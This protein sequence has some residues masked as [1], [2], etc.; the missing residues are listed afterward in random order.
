M[1]EH[2][3]MP[4]NERWRCLRASIAIDRPSSYNG[5]ICTQSPELWAAAKRIPRREMRARAHRELREREQCALAIH[6]AGHGVGAE[7]L[8]IPCTVISIEPDWQR[9]YLGI[10]CADYTARARHSANLE[11][12]SLRAH[13]I[14][15][16]CGIVAEQAFDLVPTVP[17]F[18]RLDNDNDAQRVFECAVRV[19]RPINAPR[20]ATQKEAWHDATLRMLARLHSFADRLVRCHID[21]IEAVAAELL[22][23]TRL[24][25]AELQAAIAASCYGRDRPGR[26]RSA[27]TYHG[28]GSSGLAEGGSVP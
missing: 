24:D 28:A 22:A 5:L 25:G 17:L 20:N 11:R 2:G 8:G 4:I 26:R 13:G 7:S 15:S 12:T 27:N 23:K 18:D 16:F 14:I 9:R 19:T 3:L 10:A 6:E 21:T 1:V